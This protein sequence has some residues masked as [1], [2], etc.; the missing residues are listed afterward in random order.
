MQQRSEG[1]RE[2]GFTF[3]ELMVVVSVIGILATI[4]IVSAGPIRAKQRDS[5]RISELHRFAER[6]EQYRAGKGAY[7]CGDGCMNTTLTDWYSIDCSNNAE[8]LW[9]DQRPEE[10][11]GFLNGG[12]C[13]N[14]Q[15]TIPSTGAAVNHAHGGFPAPASLNDDASWGLYR[16][17]YAETSLLIDPLEGTPKNGINYTYC[18]STP[19]RGRGSYALFARLESS[20]AGAKDGGLTDEWYEILGSNYPRNGW[21]PGIPPGEPL[22]GNGLV[23]PAGGEQCDDDNSLNNDRCN[24]SC[25]RTFCGD[26]IVQ[27]PNGQGQIETC[28]PP[29][30]APVCPTAPYCG[31]QCKM[32]T[33]CTIPSTCPNGVINVGEVC[34]GFNLGGETCESQG[35][36]GGTLGCASDCKSFDLA[37]CWQL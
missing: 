23:E 8:T 24:N 4:A 26:T 25:T 31:N 29:R 32:K 19:V 21:Y 18:F 6:L 30:A 33:I 1:R 37:Q 27:S 16:H 2:G 13:C 17:G 12:D 7:V 35:R 36:P 15:Y 22:C 34:D 28:E 9:G 10:E 3:V 5:E 20:Y 14:L 11:N